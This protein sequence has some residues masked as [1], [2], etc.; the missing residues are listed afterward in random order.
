[1]YGRTS[2][3]EPVTVTPGRSPSR[4]ISAEGSAPTISSFIA[5]RCAFSSGHTSAQ[6]RDMHSWFG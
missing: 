6:K 5:G 4:R 2:G 3:T 1:M